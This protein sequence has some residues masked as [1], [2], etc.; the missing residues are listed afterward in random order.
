[1]I[2]IHVSSLNGSSDVEVL[3]NSGADIS[4]ASK[5]VVSHLSEN[6]DNLVPSQDC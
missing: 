6:V 3:P 1:M 5:E 4:A 2:T